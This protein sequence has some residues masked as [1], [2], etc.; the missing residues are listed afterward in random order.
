MS[1][2]R[3]ECEQSHGRNKRMNENIRKQLAKILV[4]Y[5]YRKHKL[6][7]HINMFIFTNMILLCTISHQQFDYYIITLHTGIK[8]LNDYPYITSQQNFLTNW[9]KGTTSPG[10]IRKY[11]CLVS[12]FTFVIEQK[13]TSETRLSNKRVDTKNRSKD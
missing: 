10:M 3:R 5:W 11:S 12:L 7:S 2:Y 13:F 4:G 8:W 1:T 6:S 9:N